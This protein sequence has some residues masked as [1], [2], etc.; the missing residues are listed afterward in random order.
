M[1]GRTDGQFMTS[2]RQMNSLIHHHRWGQTLIAGVRPEW[3]FRLWRKDLRHDRQAAGKG[4]GERGTR[5]NGL[6][7]EM[8]GQRRIRR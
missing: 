8:K 1:I 7:R 6:R 3:H 5:N 4:R 2:A